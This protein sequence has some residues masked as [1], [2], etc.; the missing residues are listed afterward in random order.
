MN[1]LWMQPNAELLPA[2]FTP[3]ISG[4]KLKPFQALNQ[5]AALQE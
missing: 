1:K 2:A 4:P 3:T 5:F